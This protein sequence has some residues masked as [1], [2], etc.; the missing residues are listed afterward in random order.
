MIQYYM[1]CGAVST[2]LL[3]RV[4][5]SVRFANSLEFCELADDEIESVIETE[6][7]TSKTLDL[8]EIVKEHSAII[9]VRKKR[10]F[11]KSSVYNILPDEP[12]FICPHADCTVQSGNRLQLRRHYRVHMERKHV[13]QFCEQ[14]FLYLKDKRTHERIHTGERPFVCDICEKGFTQKCTLLNHLKTH[15]KLNKEEI[16]DLCGKAYLYKK[17]LAQH[18][19]E[20]HAH[21][22][23]IY[24]CKYC[25]KKYT[26]RSGFCTHLRKCT[27][28]GQVFHKCETCSRTYQQL[29]VLKRHQLTCTGRIYQCGVCDRTLSTEN[30]LSRHM[31][32]KHGISYSDCIQVHVEGTVNTP[33]QCIPISVETIPTGLEVGQLDSNASSELYCVEVTN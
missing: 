26:G 7:R 12:P 21:E 24:L 10:Q 8:S 6:Q 9:P 25:G 20:K 33:K 22:P 23:K 18:K 28:A 32:Q 27:K 15:N 2:K 11:K 3:I 16:C 5:A 17:S 14:K 4:A 1:R 30:N 19:K 31:L 29:E 13:C